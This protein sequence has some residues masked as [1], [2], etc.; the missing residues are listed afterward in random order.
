MCG[1]FGGIHT[2]FGE[3]TLEALRHRGPDQQHFASYPIDGG[4]RLDWGQTRLNV[5]DQHDVALPIR[6]RGAT[7]LFNGEIYNHRALRAELEALGYAFT[8]RTD[9]EVALAAYL[10]WGPACLD[11]FNGMFALAIWDGRA[12]F[13]AR[14]RLGQKPLFYRLGR[15]SFELASEVKAFDQL[16]FA[17]SDVFDLFEFCFDGHTPYR[18]IRALE[19]GHHLTYTPGEGTCVVRAWWDIPR[20]V[21]PQLSREDEAV[22]RFIALLEDAV[23]LRLAADVPV[24]MFMS[25]GIDSSLLAAIA[26]RVAPLERVF[27][28]QF[29]ELEGSIDEAPYARDLAGRLG[30]R[31]ELVTPTKAELEASLPALARHLEIPTG[32]FSVFPLYRLAAEARRFGYE[33]VLSGEGSDELF[34]GYARHEFLLEPPPPA[35]DKRAQY[36]AMLERFEGDGLDRFCRMASR[37]GLAGA[38]QLRMFLHSRWNDHDSLAQNICYLESKVFLQPLLQMADRMT[39]AHGVEARCP[40][41]DHRIVELAFSLSDDLRYRD[42]TGKWL[43]RRAAER[44]LPRGSAVLSRPVKHGLATPVNLWLQGHHSFDRRHWNAILTAE[45]IRQLLRA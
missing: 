42:G 18:D 34:A 40:F 31:L 25:G 21:E 8:T 13:C 7:I 30:L 33:V 11:R 22:D 20:R 41:L 10:A 9:T 4:L 1:I 36:A 44:I 26:Q 39:M 23:R 2:R 43:V 37:S 45:C 29:R 24:S 35:D 19:P 12:L 32:S 27:T 6:Q 16:G 28:C 38:A 3:H 14:D 17:S 5:V 15:G